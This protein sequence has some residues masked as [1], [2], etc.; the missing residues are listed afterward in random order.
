MRDPK[1]KVIWLLIYRV[2]RGEQRSLTR[3]LRIRATLMY[4]KAVRAARRSLI[5]LIGLCILFVFL[6]GGFLLFHAGLFF[7]LPCE[8]AEKGELFM[9]LGG[10]YFL[11]T[12]L[13]CVVSLSQR[14]WMRMTGADEAV[15]NALKP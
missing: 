15:R 9:W 8:P 1:E 10:G 6:F 13:I 12:L 7:Y 14:R 5:G 4:V 11:L 2:L 3:P